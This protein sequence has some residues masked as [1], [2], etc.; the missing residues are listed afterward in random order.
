MKSTNAKVERFIV[1]VFQNVLDQAIDND[2]RKTA[3][4]WINIHVWK[5]LLMFD[6]L[7][8]PRIRFY[9]LIVTLR[10]SR[11]AFHKRIYSILRSCD[12][13]RITLW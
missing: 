12:T 9:Q 4:G 10:W 7:Q 2:E 13:A 6:Q 3:P 8:V 1:F 11:D 5:R